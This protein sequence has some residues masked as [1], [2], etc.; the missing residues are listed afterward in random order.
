MCGSDE[1]SI[2]SHPDKREGEPLNP[3]RI[4]RNAGRSSRRGKLNDTTLLQP[5]YTEFIR[6]GNSGGLTLKGEKVSVRTSQVGGTLGRGLFAVVRLEKGTILLYSGDVLGIVEA[7]ERVI[8]RRGG[9]LLKIDY[10]G[11]YCVDGIVFAEAISKEPDKNGCFLALHEW[12]LNAGPGSM[13][14]QNREASNA[15]YETRFFGA[16]RLLAYKII[17][18]TKPVDPSEEI[19]VSTYGSDTPFIDAS[20][21]RV[22]QPRGST[23][24]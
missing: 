22:N 14:N 5:A 2:M 4:P 10:R 23:H 6:F 11:D 7:R 15:K 17:V 3:I 16:E 12:A 21:A 24:T 18:L 19:C 8:N 20:T 13:V 9:Y 1:G